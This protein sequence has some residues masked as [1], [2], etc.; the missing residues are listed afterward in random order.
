MKYTIL[1]MVRMPAI[2]V[3]ALAFPLVLMCVFSMMFTSID[4]MEGFDPIQIVV[5][6]PQGLQGGQK[7]PDDQAFEAFIKALSEGDDR[8]F[9]VEYAAS[10]DDAQRLVIDTASSDN[11]CLGYVEL[12]EGVPQVRIANTQT[13]A[14]TTDIQASLLALVMDEYVAKSTLIKE[15]IADNPTPLAN[16][17][18][19]EAIYDQTNATERIEVTKNQPRESV[20]YYFALL[21]MAALFGASLSLVAFQRMRADVSALGARR[22]LGSLSHGK[23]VV[24]TL[25]ACW[26]VEFSCLA[27][28]YAFMR[29]GIGIDFDGRDAACLLVI[30]T[31]SLTAMSLGCAISAIPKISHDGKSGIL[32]GIVCFTAFFAGLY[33]Q[34][35]MEVSDTIAMQVPLVAWLNPA[36]QIAQAFYSVMYY[37]TLYP[38]LVHAAVLVVMSVALFCLAIG[39]IRRQRYASV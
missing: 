30:A 15:M 14:G 2:M 38:M 37:D 31:A 24:A 39:S 25:C 7:M 3:W 32:T 20:R 18:L 23:A 1:E 11:A 19:Q 26:L 27:I 9:D 22:M 17:A 29:V 4:E 13:L 8:L 5:V 12:I 16:P 21:G 6:E 36:E 35:T 10:A 28:A 34:P 33:G